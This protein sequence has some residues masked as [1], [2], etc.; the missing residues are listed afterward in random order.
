MNILFCHD[1]PVNCD[2]NGRYY[3]IGFNDKLLD[4]YSAVFGNVGIVTRV[5]RTNTLSTYTETDKLTVDKY[6]VIEHPN[7]LT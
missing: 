7:Y 4:R 1:G 2:E 3:S 5:D 6:K